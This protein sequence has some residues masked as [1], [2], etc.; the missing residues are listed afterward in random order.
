MVKEKR[1]EVRCSRCDDHLCILLPGSD[2][3]ILM[4]YP[5]IQIEM[6]DGKPL[7]GKI[8]DVDD[9]E[10]ADGNR[11]K[12]RGC[13]KLNELEFGFTID[14]VV[15]R[16]PNIEKLH[17]RESMKWI[18]QQ[19]I[20]GR[21]EPKF[22]QRLTNVAAKIFPYSGPKIKRVEERV[23]KKGR[24]L[25]VYGCETKNY[26]VEV[27]IAEEPEIAKIVIR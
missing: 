26:K 20:L 22:P 11:I 10:I 16:P 23:P 19:M 4:Q 6:K 24:C 12:C 18:N 1:K 25:V 9:N 2:K 5:S 3:I 13:T 17:T 8:L 15:P 14:K 27:T 7:D 21:R